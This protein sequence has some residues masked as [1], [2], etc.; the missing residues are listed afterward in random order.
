ML[1]R[2]LI[3]AFIENDA[4]AEDFWEVEAWDKEE[5]ARLFGRVGDWDKGI[6]FFSFRALE[7]MVG[8]GSALKRRCCEMS[9]GPLGHCSGLVSE[10]RFRRL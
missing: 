3:G 1:S 9:L 2:G 10:G 5:S 4:S 8:I 6:S 7:R